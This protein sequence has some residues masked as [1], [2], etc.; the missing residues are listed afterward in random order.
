MGVIL[1]QEQHT[2]QNLWVYSVR[3]PVIQPW[4]LCEIEL[5]KYFLSTHN[6]K[7][8]VFPPQKR[9]IKI[10]YC[11]KEEN[12][13]REREC[14]VHELLCLSFIHAIRVHEAISKMHSKILFSILRRI[15]TY[16]NLWLVNLK[17]AFKKTYTQK[18]LHGKVVKYLVSIW[19][20]TLFDNNNNNYK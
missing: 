19:S 9:K 16:R 5:Y 7:Q 2:A 14:T 4:I 11:T 13:W 18:L 20:F 17:Y 3:L 1:S 12:S 8:Y 10:S 15:F 6:H